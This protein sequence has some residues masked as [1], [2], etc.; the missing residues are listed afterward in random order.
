M[1]PTPPTYYA[2][3]GTIPPTYIIPLGS[4]LE[5]GES[6]TFTITMLAPQNAPVGS[7]VT[8][9][10]IR[11]SNSSDSVGGPTGIGCGDTVSPITITGPG[12]GEPGTVEIEG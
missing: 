12:L 9:G 1:A 10:Q 5:P 2:S 11:I 4:P 3:G 6:E 8:P 7:S